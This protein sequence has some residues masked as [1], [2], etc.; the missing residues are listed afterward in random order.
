MAQAQRVKMELSAD[1]R[2]MI[3]AYRKGGPLEVIDIIKELL[4]RE[5]EQKQRQAGIIPFRRPN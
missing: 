2:A 1:E 5:D 3:L 4:H